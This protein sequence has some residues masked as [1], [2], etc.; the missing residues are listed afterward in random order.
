MTRQS[1]PSTPFQIHDVFAPVS[2]ALEVTG[3]VRLLEVHGLT[4]VTLIHVDFNSQAGPFE[5]GYERWIEL[6]DDGSL[7]KG[8]DPYLPLVSLPKQLP[9]KALKRL[10]DVEEVVGEISQN[11]ASYLRP[12]ATLSTHVRRIAAAK[13]KSERTI[14]RWLFEWLRAGR[15]SLAVVRA[16]MDC[17]LD[18][19][20][21]LDK[22]TRQP[23]P[24]TQGRKRGVLAAIPE[25]HGDFPS[26]E[27]QQAIERACDLYVVKAGMT[28]RS[29]YYE[30]IIRDFKVPPEYVVDSDEP[31]LFLSPELISRFRVPTWHQFR[32]RIRVK[33]RALRADQTD[34]DVKAVGEATDKVFGPGF[35]EID[36]T[37]IQIQL[38]SRLT[39]SK[40]VGRPTVYLIVD[41]FTGVIVGYAVTLDNPSWAVAALALNNTFSDKGP[42]FQRLGLP[43]T[44]ADWPCQELPTVLR[45]DRAELVSNMGQTFPSSG[46]RVEITEPYAPN[47]KGTVEG[48][49]S[50]VKRKRLGRFDL[51]GLFKKYRKRGEGDGKDTAALNLFQFERLLVEIIMDLNRRPVQ[52]KRL[53]KEA[54]SEGGRVA[55]RIGFYNWALRNRPGFTRAMGPNFVFEHL[56]KRGKGQVTGAGI[57]F[58]NEVY[59]SDR[60]YEMGYIAEGASNPFEIAVAYDPNFAA[61]IHVFDSQ[62]N[63]WI[64]AYNID[65]DVARVK[66]SF[67]EQR[68]FRA[69]QRRTAE[70]ADL[71]HHKHAR[72]REP[73]IKQEVKAAVAEKNATSKLHGKGKSDIRKHRAEERASARGS[74]KFDACKEGAH[75][76]AQPKAAALPYTSTG[77]EVAAQKPNA[78]NLWK[79]VNAVRK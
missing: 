28:F 18:S 59:R 61:E 70:Q 14:R 23:K 19:D 6:L 2:A 40:L 22:G 31:E 54:L 75:I 26:H 7:V 5:M 11:S 9:P 48:K 45:A 46:I 66:P 39:K 55:S 79:M 69:R 16:F 4:A 60:L 32:Y 63:K 17:P 67:D 44:S 15:N 78:K 37:H 42:V 8:L 10:K 47:K 3:A 74:I 30:M 52:P 12:K 27:L 33:L 72:D 76:G 29:A 43:Y 25:L 64:V 24:Q 58:R 56:L 49:N 62:A 71:A 57:K 34:L 77:T 20:E 1:Q 35:Y 73:S 65:P 53:P 13:G 21:A 38:V 41:I 51:P 36:A 50:E 68:E